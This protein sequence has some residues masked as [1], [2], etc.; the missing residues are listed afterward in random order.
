MIFYFK[1]NFLCNIIKLTDDNDPTEY[2][3]LELSKYQIAVNHYLTYISSY[4]PDI[5]SSMEMTSRTKF[6]L[7][8]SQFDLL[9]DVNWKIRYSKKDGFQVY[10]DDTVD[11][12]LMIKLSL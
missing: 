12:I 8:K 10:I 1:A 11:K 9:K 7:E 4:N 2:V 5:D 6:W 3:E